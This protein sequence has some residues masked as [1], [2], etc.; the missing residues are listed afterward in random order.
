MS[1][2]IFGSAEDVSATSQATETGTIRSGRTR[3]FGVYLDSGT[4]SGDF[5]LRDGGSGGTL[6]FKVKTPAAVGGIT[7]NFPGPILFENDVYCNFTT[8]HVI[9]ATVFHSK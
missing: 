5:H 8:E 1:A 6:K 2:N 9:E 7:I 3:V 4:A